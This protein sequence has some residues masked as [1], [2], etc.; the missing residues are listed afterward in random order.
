MLPIL[1][2]YKGLVLI[3][4]GGVASTVIP[5]TLKN[6]GNV[7]HFMQNK[8]PINSK[9]SEFIYLLSV[10]RPK[11]SLKCFFRFL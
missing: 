1:A 3:T 9:V 5:K 2:A 11:T 7:T 4:A 10:N 6:R 8:Q